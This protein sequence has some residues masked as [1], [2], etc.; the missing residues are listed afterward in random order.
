MIRLEL[1]H[2]ESTIRSQL[3]QL[4]RDVSAATDTKL[5][6]GLEE[7]SVLKYVFGT[8]AVVVS[9]ILLVGGLFGF[10]KMDD[11]QRLQK[12]LESELR[13]VKH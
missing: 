9:L 3:Q 4:S 13:L 10:F 2:T 12:Q 7:V 11:L 6:K 5:A 8:I 1:R